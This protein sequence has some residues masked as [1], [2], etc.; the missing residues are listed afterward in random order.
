M[1]K[2]LSTLA[3][4]AYVLVAAVVLTLGVAQ[5]QPASAMYNCYFPPAIG[6]CCESG[7]DYTDDYDCMEGCESEEGP[8]WYIMGFCEAGCCTCVE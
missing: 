3:K 1:S 7:C 8:P 4:L 5:L 6:T 2:F